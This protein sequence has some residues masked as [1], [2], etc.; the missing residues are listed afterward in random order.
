MLQ[1]NITKHTNWVKSGPASFPPKFLLD[2]TV[3]SNWTAPRST[4]PL[5]LLLRNLQVYRAISPSHGTAKSSTLPVLTSTARVHIGPHNASTS[6]TLMKMMTEMYSEMLK[7][8]QNRMRINTD[9]R[10]YTLEKTSCK[11]AF[12]KVTRIRT[13]ELVENITD[14]VCISCGP[15]AWYWGRTQIERSPWNRRLH[16]LSHILKRSPE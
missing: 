7:Q 4:S 15:L 3:H 1:Y 6:F 12:S 9:S 11:M 10:N 2:I 14:H 8:P 16:D 5:L 13:S